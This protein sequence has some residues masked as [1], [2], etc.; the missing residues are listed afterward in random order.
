MHSERY[1]KQTEGKGLY[2]TAWQGDT[3]TGILFVAWG[4]SVAEVVRASFPGCPHL[5]DLSVLPEYRRQGI[6]TQL[7]DYAETEARQRGHK[8]IGLDVDL[9]LPNCR[10]AHGI[11][12]RRGYRDTGIEHM[13]S[14]TALDAS[15][16]EAV[17]EEKLWSMVKELGSEGT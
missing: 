14:Y 9:C 1:H 7:L 6:A 5:T 11:Y 17:I 10:I 12:S 15:G 2:A 13:D 16:R 4:G 3:P 8:R